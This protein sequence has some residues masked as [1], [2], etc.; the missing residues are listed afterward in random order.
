MKKNSTCVIV[1]PTHKNSFTVNE[2][3][4]L[5]NTSDKLKNFKIVIV[6][7]KDLDT[8]PIKKIQKKYKLQLEI[9]IL[10][11]NFLGSIEKY[12]RMALSKNFYKLFLDFDYMLIVHLDAYIFKD[13]LDYWLAQEYDYIGAPLFLPIKKFN[14]QLWKKMSPYGGNGGLSLRNVKKHF[15]LTSGNFGSKKYSLI[16]KGVIFLLKNYRFHYVLIFLNSILQLSKNP[17]EFREKYKIYEDVMISI[18]YNFM[19][20]NFRVAPSKIARY[21]ALEVNAEYIITNKSKFQLPFGIHGYDKYWSKEN[22]DDFIRKTEKKGFLKNKSSRIIKFSKSD[23]PLVSIITPVKDLIIQKRQES[24]LQTLDSI[25]DQTYNRIEHLV[26]VGKSNDTTK[27]FV[28]DLQK[29]YSYKIVY[30]KNKG[31]WDAMDLGLFSCNGQ[32]VNYLNSDDYYSKKYTVEKIIKT[33]IKRRALWAYSGGNLFNTQGEFSIFPTSKFGVFSC[34]GII[35]QTVFVESQLLKK[36][37]TFKSQSVTRENLLFLRLILNKIKSVYVKESLVNYR[38]GGFSSNDY[39][40]QN[41]QK[42]KKDFGKYL[43][44]NWGQFL[45]IT[46]EEC[47]LFFGLDFFPQMGYKFSFQLIKKIRPRNLQLYMLMK[48]FHSFRHNRRFQGIKLVFTSK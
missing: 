5:C 22:F 17:S 6:V 18:F 32:I 37:N 14:S 16:V 34:I 41:T 30:Q 11:K 15:D 13:D 46:N 29:I 27:E 25:R 35:H 26:V 21:F 24:F 31:V 28:K 45:Q 9:K 48:F 42:T 3:K 12:N 20:K 8:E 38:L 36:F 4:S 10:Q 33:M 23:T 19:D 47:E 44:N 2:I 43:Y 1:I 7:P 39:G 40:G